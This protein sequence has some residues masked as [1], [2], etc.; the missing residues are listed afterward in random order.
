VRSSC[1]R[2]RGNVADVMLEEPREQGLVLEPFE[3]G[4]VVRAPRHA[5]SRLAELCDDYR[6]TSES[7]RV[8][9]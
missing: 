1:P 6:S 3:E 9:F 7:G 4:F 2:A 5:T 8:R